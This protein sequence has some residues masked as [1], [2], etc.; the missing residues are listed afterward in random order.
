MLIKNLEKKIKK[1]ISSSYYEKLEE[2]EN[3]TTTSTSTSPNNYYKACPEDNASKWSKISFSWVTKL[4][5]KGYFK[6]SLEMNDIY[7]LPQSNKVQTTSKL[8]D[9]IQFS[10]VSKYTLIKHIYKKFLPKNIY[11]LISNIFITIFT[12]LSPIF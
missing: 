1:K 7:D 5:I 4:I 6:E 8:L 12:F 2:D 10:E 9:N 11:A 3:E